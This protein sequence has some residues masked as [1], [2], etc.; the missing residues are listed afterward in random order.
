MGSQTRYVDGDGPL[1]RHH[2]VPRSRRS[3]GRVNR[4]NCLFH[5]WW[6]WLFLNM[7]LYESC[8]MVEYMMTH[9]GP[10]N[11]DSW[12]WRRYCLYRHSLMNEM[13]Q[14]VA[15][16]PGFNYWTPYG[17]DCIAPI[18]LDDKSEQ[19]AQL[20]RGIFGDIRDVCQAHQFMKA[21]MQP[22]TI[23]KIDDIIELRKRVIDGA[24][25]QELSAAAS[26]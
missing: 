25:K 17:S 14:R 22:G 10:P 8:Y 24:S 21:L 6:H 2:I 16:T 11:A 9:R 5:D 3:N 19:W 26:F 13:D 1:G 7:T 12:G 4:L 20:W 18:R 15:L 23:W